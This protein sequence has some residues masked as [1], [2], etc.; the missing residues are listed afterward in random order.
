[1]TLIGCSVEEIKASPC[2]CR[3]VA[4]VGSREGRESGGEMRLGRSRE[5][6]DEGINLERVCVWGGATA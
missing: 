6:S 3:A 1:M 2:W 4:D 5:E